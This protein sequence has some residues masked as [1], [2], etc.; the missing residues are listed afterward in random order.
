[1]K[2]ELIKLLNRCQ[3]RPDLFNELILKRAPYWSRQMDLCRSVVEYRTTVAYSG[4]MVGKDFWIAGIVLWWLLTRPKSLCIITGPSQMVLGSVTFKEIRR[5]LDGALLPFG[6]KLSSG[7][8]AS[9]AV[10]EIAPGWQALG[11]STTSVE[12]SSGQHAGHLLAVVEEAPGVEDY[13]FDAIDSL[14]YE[15]LVCIGNPIRAEGKFVD[16]IRQADRDRADNVPPRLAVNAIRIPST[17][18]PHAHQEKSPFG[19]ADKTWLDSMY[20]KYGKGSLWVRSHIEARIPDVSAEQLIDPTWL[21]HH[22]SQQRPGAPPTHPIH[23]T[24]RIA[25][26]LSE[27]VGRD[28]TCIMVVD[29]WGVLE[30]VLSSDA[31]LPEAAATIHRLVSKWQVPHDR[32]TYDKLGIGRNFPNHLARHGITTAIPYA[33]EGRPQ[34]P[35]SYVNLRTEA[36]WKLHNRLNTTHPVYAPP[37][38]GMPPRTVPQRD[39]YFCPGDYY[40]RLV[41]E[42][43][44]L[45]YSLVGRKT[46]LMPKDEWATIL[47]HSPD[48]ADALIQSMILTP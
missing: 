16:L 2:N 35:N 30:V 27:G 28:S 25:C 36:G 21:N 14:G 8:K 29:D 19:L 20:R 17:E 18:S 22:S 43:R 4:N 7:L 24:R 39:F 31:G 1:M 5:C 44:P 13:V 10:I 38:P 34:D 33:G 11:F 26:D 32:I 46:K 6:G 48:V 12:R 3:D 15:R 40:V 47:G 23:R 45:T 42:L 9:P 41:E 37:A